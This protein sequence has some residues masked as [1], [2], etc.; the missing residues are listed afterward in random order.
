MS[1]SQSQVRIFFN[2][3]LLDEITTLNHDSNVHGILV[4]L[5]LPDGFDEKQVTEAIDVQKDVDG[6]HSVNIG[7][8]A[9]RDTEPLFL[10][11]TPKGIMEL[12]KSISC[13]LKGK[14]AVVV[15]RSNIVGMP[16]AHL[17]QSKDATV[18]VCHSKTVNIESI[19]REA[20]VLVVAIGKPNLIPGDWLKP[21]VV[22][23]DVGT[24]AVPDASK[25]S[26]V[27]WVGDVEF[28]SASKVA[29]HITPVPGGVGP[30]TVAMLLD[31]TIISAQ[32]FLKGYRIPTSYSQLNIMDPVPRYVP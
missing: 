6:F 23:I 12:L 16:I 5:P 15:G 14:R 28:N 27:R 8:L 20:D 7:Q 26:G 21:G 25:K 32:R 1:V 19:V 3:K 13:D 2:Y 11:C 4:Q 31:N 17:L 30:M 18:T 29:S 24:N 22:V 9:K 10:P